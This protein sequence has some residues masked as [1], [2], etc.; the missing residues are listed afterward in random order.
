MTADCIMPSLLYVFKIPLHAGLTVL[1]C[2]MSPTKRFIWDT[3]FAVTIRKVQCAHSLY[4]S[5]LCS[6]TFK[7]NVI[8]QYLDITG[9]RLGERLKLTVWCDHRGPIEHGR[10]TDQVPSGRGTVV[11]IV[12]CRCHETSHRKIT[13]YYSRYCTVAFCY[14]HKCELSYMCPG[15]GIKLNPHRGKLYRI[16]CAGS[17]LILAIALA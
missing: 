5:Y 4:V 9:F 8:F 14:G 10:R 13:R 3:Y 7:V 15:H 2:C 1:A 12:S 16:G 11:S 6:A 17:S